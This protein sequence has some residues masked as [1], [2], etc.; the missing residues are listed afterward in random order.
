ME[1]KQHTSEEIEPRF[2]CAGRGKVIE[3]EFEFIRAF[4]INILNQIKGYS[5]FKSETGFVTSLCLIL[6]VC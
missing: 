2:S 3:N 6:Y 5:Y 4:K 1:G